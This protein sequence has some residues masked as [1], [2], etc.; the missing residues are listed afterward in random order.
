MG[1]EGLFRSGEDLCQCLSLCPMILLVFSHTNSFKLLKI[2][3]WILQQR[4]WQGLYMECF[5]LCIV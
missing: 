2:V 3:I 5:L 1:G 4:G